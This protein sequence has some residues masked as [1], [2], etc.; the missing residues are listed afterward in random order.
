M[1]DRPCVAFKLNY[2]DGGANSERVGFDGVCSDENIFCNIRTA[3]RRWCSNDRCACKKYL[4]GRNFRRD[5]FICYE[6]AFF[7]DWRVEVGED[8]DG[9]RR[10]IRGGAENHLCVLTTREPH[11]A[12]TERFVFALFLIKNIFN[13]NAKRTGCVEAHDYWRLEFRPREAAQIKFGDVYQNPNA[14][15]KKFWGTGL[16]RY[17]DDTTAIKFLERAADVKRGTLEENFA[18][19]FLENYH[20]L[21]WR[22]ITTRHEVLD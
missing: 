10:T 11:A 7:R 15:H 18:K 4:D 2:C 5:E 16:F 9:T 21:R 19:K 8:T 22:I 14:P 13:G 6:S 12:E 17:F 3:K 20:G 1:I